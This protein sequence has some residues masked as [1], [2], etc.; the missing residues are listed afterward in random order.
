MKYM[1]ETWGEF[2]TRTFFLL[3]LTK[4]LFWILKNKT[5]KLIGIDFRSLECDVCI[6]Q[7]SRCVIV[8]EIVNVQKCPGLYAL[9]ELKRKDLNAR[10]QL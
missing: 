7:I 8:A 2:L 3:S 5:T 4:V 10:T 6:P 1:W 9:Q